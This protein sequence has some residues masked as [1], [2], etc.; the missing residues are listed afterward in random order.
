MSTL[1]PIVIEKTGR[2]ER[3]K[4]FTAAEAKEYG[5]VDEVFTPDKDKK[6]KDKASK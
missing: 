3:D 6:K 2:G 5:I 1:V 4:Y